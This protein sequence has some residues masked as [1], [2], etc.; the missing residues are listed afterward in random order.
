[1]KRLKRKTNKNATPWKNK[2]KKDAKG[3]EKNDI[4]RERGKTSFWKGGGFIFGL[5]IDPCKKRV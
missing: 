5:N 3:V 2:G 4:L 1:M